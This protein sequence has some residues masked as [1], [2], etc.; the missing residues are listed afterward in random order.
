MGLDTVE[1]IMAVEVH[2]GISVPDKRAEKIKT[3]EQ[4]AQLIYELSAQTCEPRSYEQVVWQLRLL[5]AGRFDIALEHIT[6]A[7]RFIE[8]LGL[9]Q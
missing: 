1:L 7:S 5:I 4:L 8:D 9:D 2:F 3:V 6:G